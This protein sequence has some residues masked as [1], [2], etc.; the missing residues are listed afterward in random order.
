MTPLLQ[1]SQLNCNEGKYLI[2]QYTGPVAT[3]VSSPS[4]KCCNY[5]F[6]LTL[7]YVSYFH[8]VNDKFEYFYYMLL[9]T[10]TSLH[11]RGKCRTFTPL[12]LFVSYS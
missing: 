10:R 2:V 11:L 6:G 3:V 7:I 5:N 1:L 4:C 8:A 9:Y 12:H